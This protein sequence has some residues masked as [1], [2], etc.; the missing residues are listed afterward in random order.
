MYSTFYYTYH[1]KNIFIFFLTKK[2][3]F[4]NIINVER[5]GV[6]MKRFYKISDTLFLEMGFVEAINKWYAD[7]IDVDTHRIISTNSNT[8]ET[9]LIASIVRDNWFGS[10]LENF[11]SFIEDILVY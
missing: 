5:Q 7:L 1:I 2:I 8:E 10:N 9:K 3:F 6:N 11:K 4:V